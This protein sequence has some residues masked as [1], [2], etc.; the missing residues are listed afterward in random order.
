MSQS[1]HTT[2]E[3]EDVGKV[4]EDGPVSNEVDR[5]EARYRAARVRVADVALA[6]AIRRQRERDA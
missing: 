4:E 5:A 1:E 3:N 6:D 2:E